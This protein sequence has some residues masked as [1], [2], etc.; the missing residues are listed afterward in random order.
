MR[1]WGLRLLVVAVIAGLVWLVGWSN[2]LAVKNV[3]VVGADQLKTGVVKKA[4]GIVLG[5]PLVRVDTGRAAESV[6]ELKRVE[7]VEVS[8]SWPRTITI[9]IVE[10]API[11]WYMSGGRARLFDRHGIVFESRRRGPTRLA[12]VDYS[13]PSSDR[14]A[15]IEEVAAVIEELRD[16]ND[17][18]WG[19]VDRIDVTSRDSIEFIVADGTR[20]RWGS[21]KRSEEK[22]AVLKVLRKH[23]AQVY[24][25]TAP[26]QPTTIR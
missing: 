10:R 18:L 21:A 22:L 3:E 1:T 7:K 6:E 17:A 8:R 16:D 4:A 11:G 23:K 24:D 15:A 13:G 20:I 5:E 2:V 12:R 9:D 14:S 19:K 26:N 25:V